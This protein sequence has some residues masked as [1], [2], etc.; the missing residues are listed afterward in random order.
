QSARGPAWDQELRRNA[1]IQS[2][3]RTEAGDRVFFGP[4]SAELGSRARTALAAQA[5]WLMRWHEFE[6]AIEGHA[7]EPGTEQENVVL[8]EQRAEAVRQRLIDEGVEPNRLAVV[9]L[10]R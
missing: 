1:S 3:L 6:A 9:P 5:Q 7:D 8:S 10:G 2:K 4:G